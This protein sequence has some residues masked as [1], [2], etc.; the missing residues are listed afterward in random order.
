M[1]SGANP[2]G[3]AIS[4]GNGRA[5]TGDAPRTE[6]R[7]AIPTVRTLRITAT[8]L[9]VTYL[10]SP[11]DY[12]RAAAIVQSRPQQFVE[13]PGDEVIRFLDGVG[14]VV[15]QARPARRPRGQRDLPLGGR[16][17]RRGPVRAD[18]G[19]RRNPPPDHRV[20]PE[21]AKEY[22]PAQPP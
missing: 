16:T 18:A 22:P 1:P 20:G 2:L 5:P 17:L 3:R 8:P 12:D 10:T 4:D 13:L 21:T 19:D 7:T 14:G 6:S 11:R 9:S 15:S